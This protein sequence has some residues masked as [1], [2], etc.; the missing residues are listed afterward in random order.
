MLISR[1]PTG[2]RGR[3]ASVPRISTGSPKKSQI[4]LSKNSGHGNSFQRNPSSIRPLMSALDP[5]MKTPEQPET[6][7]AP[8]GGARGLVVQENAAKIPAALCHQHGHQEGTGALASPGTER[9]STLHSELPFGCGFSCYLCLVYAKTVRITCNHD[10]FA[11]TEKPASWR[12][13]ELAN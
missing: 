2:S 12:W 9:S 5:S 1:A 4:K 8:L 6:D 13:V 11:A 3:E 7:A 10:P